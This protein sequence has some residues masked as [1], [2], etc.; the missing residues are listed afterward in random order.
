MPAKIDVSSIRMCLDMT[1][2]ESAGRFGF[3]VNALCH[4]DQDSPQREGATRAY[5]LGIERAPDPV[6]KDFR[7]A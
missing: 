1:Q 6:R 5:L 3:G 7:D 2:D 4:W